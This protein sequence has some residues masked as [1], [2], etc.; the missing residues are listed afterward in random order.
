MGNS[1]GKRNSRQSKQ[2]YNSAQR[3][4]KNKERNKEKNIKK[5]NKISERTKI[6]MEKYE[7]DNFG[8]MSTLDIFH[9]R[10]ESGEQ[11]TKTQDLKELEKVKKYK[12]RKYNQELK[13]KKN[14]NKNIRNH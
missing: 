4:L 5:Q 6:R 7:K 11:V 12:Q 1:K 2:N 14:D 8:K 9:S 10:Q 13:T 3:W